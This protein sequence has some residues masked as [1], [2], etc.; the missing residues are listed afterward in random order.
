MGCYNDEGKMVSSM[1][2]FP[3]SDMVD[4]WSGGLVYSLPMGLSSRA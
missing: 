4:F 2:S 1:F 3:F